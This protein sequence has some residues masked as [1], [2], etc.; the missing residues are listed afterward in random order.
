M[1][2]G[3]YT[4]RIAY[5]VK[6]DLFMA[7]PENWGLIFSVRTGSANF[8]HYKLAKRWVELGYKSVDGMLQKYNDEGKEGKPLAIRTEE[9]LFKLLKIPWVEPEDRN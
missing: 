1:P 7:T 9:H 6:L 2:T 8:S 4:Q 3:K 5:G